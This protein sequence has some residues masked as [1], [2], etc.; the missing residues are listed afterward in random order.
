MRR[1]LVSF[2]LSDEILGR[3]KLPSLAKEGWLRP[4]TRCRE[5][6]LV[7]ADGVVGLSHRLSVVE[8]TTPAAPSKE[9][10]RF[11]MAR[12]F[13]RLRPVGL[14]LRALLGQGGEFYSLAALPP[15]VSL[16]F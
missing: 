7:G 1:S 6:S 5:A 10:D 12:H 8:R 13:L 2:C 4:S 15:Y 14:A 9:G 16:P 11:L 3:A